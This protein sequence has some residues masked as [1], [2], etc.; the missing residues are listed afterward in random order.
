VKHL[1]MA[2]L[3]VDAVAR[4]R[5]ASLIMGN[6]IVLENQTDHL[7]IIIVTLWTSIHPTA[8]RMLAIEGMLTTGGSAVVS[9]NESVIV[10]ERGIM[11]DAHMRGTTTGMMEEARR[12]ITEMIIAINDVVLGKYRLTERNIPFLS[13]SHRTQPRRILVQGVLMMSRKRSE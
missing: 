4:N 6:T 12:V 1:K 5:M 9:E 10:A 7:D 2:I 13:E 11:T 3:L 8:A